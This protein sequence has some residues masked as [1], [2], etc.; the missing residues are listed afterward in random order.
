MMYKSV[1]L[2]GMQADTHSC[3]VIEQETTKHYMPIVPTT[4]PLRATS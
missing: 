2:H 3:K 4:G 1:G